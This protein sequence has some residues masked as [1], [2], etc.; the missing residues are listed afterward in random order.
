MRTCYRSLLW[1]HPP[2]FRREFADE[3]LWIFDRAAESQ[4]TAAL[5]VDAAGSLV[6]QWLLRSGWWKIA[7]ALGLAVLQIVLGGFASTLFKPHRIVTAARDAS[8]TPLAEFSQHGSISHQPLTIG[9]VMYLAV[10]L[11]AGITIMVIGLTVWMKSFGA[12]RR[13]ALPR[14]R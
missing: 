11:T 14:G 6:R 10:F 5:F 8:L 2:A 1:L 4:S 3:M 13:P 7:L 9:I 12:R